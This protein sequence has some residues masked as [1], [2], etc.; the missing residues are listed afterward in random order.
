MKLDDILKF[1]REKR[2]IPSPNLGF[3]D[4]IKLFEKLLIEN[5]YGIDNINFKEI[6]WIPPAYTTYYYNNY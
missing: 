1:V 5:N 4:Q 6:I 2:P 3:Q